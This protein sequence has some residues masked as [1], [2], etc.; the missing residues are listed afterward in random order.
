[1]KYFIQACNNLSIERCKQETK[2]TEIPREMKKNLSPKKSHEISNMA[3]VVSTLYKKNNCDLVIDIGAGLGYV[4]EL[5][6]RVYNIPVVT[7]EGNESHAERAAKKLESSKIK[8][9]T[10]I[11][12]DSELVKEK[13][14]KIIQENNSKNPCV[15]GLHCCGDLTVNIFKLC[16]RI[17]VSVV[18]LVSCC[19]HRMSTWPTSGK[20]KEAFH[21]PLSLFGLR[22]AA[23]ETKIRWLC[24]T[25]KDHKAHIRN[26]YYR[27]ILELF[28]KNKGNMNYNI[29]NID[30]TFSL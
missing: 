23:Q 14:K 28:L 22:L 7:L 15:I 2:L 12:D 27:A 24:Q 17:N 18:C 4:S 30:I 19:Y 11:I 1:M 21:K 16:T 8:V 13:L 6:S 25:E 29:V 20:F 3:S 10:L 5:L 9:Y 26:V